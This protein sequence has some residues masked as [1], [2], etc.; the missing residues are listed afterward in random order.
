[1]IQYKYVNKSAK[2]KKNTEVKKKMKDIDETLTQPFNDREQEIGASDI[3]RE[4]T[5]VLNERYPNMVSACGDDALLR[6]G[7]GTTFKI[8][9]ETVD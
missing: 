7:N 3:V 1:M 9:V 6:F 8:H 5:L 4:L 2:S